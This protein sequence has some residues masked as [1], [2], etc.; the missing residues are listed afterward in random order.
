MRTALKSLTSNMLFQSTPVVF[1]RSSG[2]GRCLPAAA[3]DCAGRDADGTDRRLQ[4]AEVDVLPLEAGEVDADLRHVGL[5]LGP[6][7]DGFLILV[8]HL[9]REA[10]ALQFFD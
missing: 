4:V 6:E 8:Q 9:D 1:A 3:A 10:E 5:V 7:R 2:C